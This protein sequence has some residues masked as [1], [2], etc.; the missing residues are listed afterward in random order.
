MRYLLNRSSLSLR[1]KVPLQTAGLGTSSDG[2]VGVLS[3]T[4]DK[5]RDY[6]DDAEAVCLGS[7][8]AVHAAVFNG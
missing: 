6:G 8:Y 2:S 5:S 4:V 1:P 7:K 3:S